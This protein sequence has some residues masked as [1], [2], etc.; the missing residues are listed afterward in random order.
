MAPTLTTIVREAG[1]KGG[2]GII[3]SSLGF[4]DL[5]SFFSLNLG[6]GIMHPL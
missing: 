4:S 1:Y 6:F 3:T 2:F 5:E